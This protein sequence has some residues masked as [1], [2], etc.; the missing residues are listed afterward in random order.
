MEKNCN[1][2]VKNWSL[3]LF[4]VILISF[5]IVLFKK[6]V[7]KTLQNYKYKENKTIN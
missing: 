1:L 3:S 2:G 7:L 6:N 5:I 4:N